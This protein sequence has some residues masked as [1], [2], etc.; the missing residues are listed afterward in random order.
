[1]QKSKDEH[2]PEQVRG[3]KHASHNCFH[4]TNTEVLLNIQV[5]TIEKERRKLVFRAAQIVPDMGLPF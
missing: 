4:F 5:V 2:Y 3:V 1:M